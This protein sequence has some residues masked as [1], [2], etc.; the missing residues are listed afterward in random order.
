MMEIAS[1]LSYTKFH[2]IKE[3]DTA[4]KM[5]DAIEKIYRGDKNAM[6]DKS[7]SL[8]GNFD[9]MRMQ[10]GET[11]V[12]YCAR[13]KEVVNAIRGAT[14]KIEDEILINNILRTLLPIYIIRVSIIQELRCMLGNDLNLEH[15][16]GRIN[17]FEL[18]KFGNY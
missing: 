8:R 16:V 2:D 10:E 6:R 13:V 12:Q 9:D 14:G 15:L 4:K 5:W 1:T 11:M 3:C 7:K 17:T 18:S